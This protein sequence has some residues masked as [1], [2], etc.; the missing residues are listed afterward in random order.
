[1]QCASRDGA[2][3]LMVRPVGESQDLE[4]SPDSTWGLHLADVNLVLGDVLVCQGRL[5]EAAYPV[6]PTARR[7]YMSRRMA[8]ARPV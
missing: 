7:S 6:S 5:P 3:V 4:P 8:P 2:R 1:M